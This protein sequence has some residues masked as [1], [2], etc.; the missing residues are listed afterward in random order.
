M[1]VTHRIV[2]VN[3]DGTFETKGDA[4]PAEDR[5]TVRAERIVGKYTGKTRF[6]IWLDSFGDV[7]K[8]LMLL[9]IVPVALGAVFEVRSIAKLSAEAFEEKRKESEAEHERLMRE[10]IEK[11][12]LRLAEQD[13]GREGVKAGESRED[14]EA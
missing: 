3:D 8:L 9:V 1:L 7:R 13:L 10:A 12:K 11:E 5:V 14:N 2:A 6:F 4:N